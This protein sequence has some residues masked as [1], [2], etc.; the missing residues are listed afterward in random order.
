MRREFEPR[1]LSPIL[2]LYV[3]DRRGKENFRVVKALLDSGASATLVKKS[4]VQKL[5]IKTKASSTEWTSA[6]GEMTTT[7]K[8]GIQFMMPELSNSQRVTWDVHVMPD[9]LNANYDMI[10]GRDLLRELD[11]Q[12]SFAEDVIRMGTAQIPMRPPRSTAEDAFFSHI[13]EKADEELNSKYEKLLDNDYH[14]ADLPDLAKQNAQLSSEQQQKLLEL[15][16]K[17]EPLFDGTL[18]TYN[19]KQ[20]DIE[21][22]DDA[23]PF[24]LKRPYSVPHAYKAAFYKE[25]ERLCKIGVLRKIN[26]S[27]WAA[28]TFLIPKKNKQIRFIS[29]FRELNKRIKRKPYPIPK[30]QDMLMSLQGFSYATSI[31]LNMGYYH[32]EL[33]PNAQRLCT[34]VLPWGKYEYQKLPMGLSNSPDVFQECMSDLMV[35][36]EFCRVYI[37]DLLLINKGSFDEHLECIEKVFIRLQAAGFKV[38]AE[39]SFFGKQELEYLGYWVTTDSITP[40]PKKIAA[41]QALEPPKTVRQVRKFIGMVNFYRDMWIRR[42]EVLTPLTALTSKNTK[43]QWTSKEQNAFDTIKR[44]MSR[45]TQLFYPDF[46]KPFEIHTDASKYQMGA[47]LHQEG[48]PIAFYS[49]KLNSAQ[50]KY[51]VTE[52]EL[53]AIVATLKEF[54]NILLGHEVIVYTDHKNLTY[55]DFNSERVIR[56]RMALERFDIKL[57]YVR[58]EDN[59]VADALSRLEIKDET[60]FVEFYEDAY[61]ITMEIGYDPEDVPPEIFPLK[62]RNISKAQTRDLDLMRK[63]KAQTANYSIESFRGG[64]KTID[65]V[66]FKGKVYIPKSLRTHVV[67]WYHTTLCHPGENQTEHTIRQYL[68]WENLRDDVHKICSTCPTCQKNK[69]HAIKYGHLPAKIAE[70]Y[71]WETLCVDLIGPYTFKRKGKT[72]LSLW[73]V[74]MIDPATGWFEIAQIPTKESGSVANIVEQAWLTRYPWPNILVFDRGT[75][76]MG[77]F[78]KMARMDYGL[79]RKPITTRNPQANAIIERVHQT[80][81]NILRT[82]ETDELDESDP[83]SG[84][85]AATSFAVRA[86]YHTTTQ[87][88]PSQMVFG[89]DAILNIKHVTDWNKVRE[90]KQEIIRKNNIRENRKRQAHTYQVN[91]QILIK[92]NP[93]KAKFDHEWLGPYPIVSVNTNG[94]VRYQKGRKT[95]SINIRQIHPYKSSMVVNP[96]N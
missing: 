49:K 62:F 71:P 29:D 38:N 81:G 50:M 53:L 54:E 91:D 90:R 45:N 59:I 89:R 28:G 6:N 85:L 79:K 73:C 30:I 58:G 67:N 16:Q 44:I 15:L 32:I 39:K 14:K 82:F 8:C 92:N 52:K 48:R 11:I 60:H 10:I 70:T 55:K 22:Q 37:D 3:N 66:T 51:T 95:D 68:Y 26:Q 80:I 4:L 23:K 27:E 13:S 57:N 65:L 35:G 9:Q 56:Q 7:Q 47:V 40:V 46:N 96:N 34:I 64:G 41:L 18:G 72:D 69:K 1:D 20:Y 78:A 74:T 24:H 36:L 31:D 93:N 12:M 75:E 43:W 17:Y 42:S 33:T 88:T 84:I 19:G 83:W 5:K 2:F 94:T 63:L 87:T 25:V 86:T 76:F 21:L 77:E 61:D